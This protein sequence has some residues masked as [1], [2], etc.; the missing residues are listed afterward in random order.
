MVSASPAL[1]ALNA[2]V[3]SPDIEGRID[4]EGYAASCSEMVNFLCT[5]QGPVK[6]RGGTQ[7]VNEVEDSANRSWLVPFVRNRETAYVVEFADNVCRFYVDRA[8]VTSGGSPYEIASPYAASDLV[9]ADGHF[10]LS[11]VQDLDN[12]YIA[13]RSGEFPLYVLA[14]T[15]STSWSFSPV[16]LYGGPWGDYNTDSAKTIYASGTAGSVTL[17][18]GVATFSASDVGRRLWLELDSDETSAWQADT[19]VNTNDIRRAGKRYYQSQET[20]TTGTTEPT[21]THGTQHDGGVIWRFWATSYAIFE[22][23]GYTNSTTVTADVKRGDLWRSSR[24]PPGLTSSSTASDRWRWGAWDEISGYPT[25]LSFF[26]QRLVAAMGSRLDF[27]WVGD[28]TVFS[29]F[30]F[31]ETTDEVAFNIAL[32][33][34]ETDDIVGLTEGASLLVHTEGGEITVGVQTDSEPFSTTNKTYSTGTN[35]GAEPVTPTRAGT[36]ALFVEAGGRSLRAAEYSVESDGLVAADVTLRASHLTEMSQL[37]GIALQRRPQPFLWARIGDGLAALTYD[38]TSNARGWST[39][40]IAG[41]DAVESIAIV[42]GPSQVD[43]DVYLIVRRTIDGN[44]VRYI[45]VVTPPWAPADAQEDATYFDSHLVYDGAAATTISGLDHLEGE[46]VHILANGAYHP[47]RTVSGGEITLDRSTTKAC[48][49][50]Q[51]PAWF[52]TARMEAGA[53]DGTAQGKTKRIPD[54]MARVR[55]T[56]GG[57]MGPDLQTLDPVPDLNWRDPAT[58][59][60]DPDPLYSGDALLPWPGGY[61]TDGRMAFYVDGGFPATVVALFPQVSTSEAR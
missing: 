4:I 21:H 32:Q 38:Q 18:A 48:I 15:S 53:R 20:D 3:W 56:R 7:F 1:A 31:G 51:A 37:L 2:G 19:G 12:L 29:P 5:V 35:Y 6:R 17:T 42:P 36:S 9:D 47:P 59:M 13:H 34:R 55:N 23:T 28:P 16:T 45:E 46:E 10:M 60:G 26:R 57:Y 40:Q 25:V 27:S 30:D 58:P 43:D 44:T 14:R 11:V 39:A 24:V 8:V 41:A 52:I 50:L 54:V 33:S 22:I 61:E 49:G